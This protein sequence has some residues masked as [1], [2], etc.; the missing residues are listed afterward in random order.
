MM[1][2]ITTILAENLGDAS[3]FRP[4]L[5]NGLSGV[6][7]ATQDLPADGTAELA[8]AFSPHT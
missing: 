2:E 5:R 8:C 3:S 1:R 6:R 7:A 4:S